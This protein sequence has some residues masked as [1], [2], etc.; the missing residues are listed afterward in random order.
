MKSKKLG[1]PKGISNK[2]KIP[3]GNA[4]IQ[5]KAEGKRLG[6][7]PK[8]PVLEFD[9]HD[10]IVVEVSE[11]SAD[12]KK[13]TKEACEP[14]II[15]Q[16]DALGHFMPGNKEGRAARNPYRKILEKISE[17]EFTEVRNILV[18]KAK[19]GELMAIQML[20]KYVI[21]YAPEPETIA[22][23][24]RTKTVNELADSMDIVIEHMANGEISP[25]GAMNYVKCLDQKREFIKTALLETRVMELEERFKAVQ[26]R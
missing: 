1:R 12:L 2:I 21:P 9:K 23:K 13:E 10:P 6:R 4:K 11:L 15:P 20:L 19:A 17:E 18:T 24:L 3:V 5:H 8:L 26:K 7:P 16:R 25:E 14:I 22:A